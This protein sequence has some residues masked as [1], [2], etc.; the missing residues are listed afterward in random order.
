VVDRGIVIDAWV[1]VSLAG[2][3]LLTID[4]RVVVASIETYLDRNN[5]LSA[6]ALF[7]PAH[8]GRRRQS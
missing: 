7:S 3:E 8:Q 6:T 2:L 1:S 4:A 5:A